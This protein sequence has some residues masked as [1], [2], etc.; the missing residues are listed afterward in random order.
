[1]RRPRWV[2]SLTAAIQQQVWKR[3]GAAGA[4]EISGFEDC[5]ALR[6]GRPF[7]RVTILNRFVGIAE[8]LSAVD[9]I[10]EDVRERR[11]KLPHCVERSGIRVEFYAAYRPTEPAG[12]MFHRAA[13]IEGFRSVRRQC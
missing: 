4:F 9:T 11:P 1:M 8:F 6:Q 10:E 2:S 5:G 3:L 13:L 12:E 7:F